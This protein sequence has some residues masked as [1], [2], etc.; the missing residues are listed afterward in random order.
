MERC[1]IGAWPGVWKRRLYGWLRLG[2]CLGLVVSAVLLPA[3]SPAV[4]GEAEEDL[5]EVLHVTPQQLKAGTAGE[6]QVTLH[7]PE[8]YHL[9][10]RAPLSYRIDVQGEG[11]HIAEADRSREVIAPALPLVIPLQTSAGTHQSTAALDMTFYYCREDD[12]GVCVIQSVRWQVPLQTTPEQTATQA[13]LSY[14]AE[15][16]VVQRPL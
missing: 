13:R 12:T 16:P 15:V 10:P 5:V 4:A 11:I 9:N 14:K 2:V 3:A 1:R 8:G 7:F 6:L